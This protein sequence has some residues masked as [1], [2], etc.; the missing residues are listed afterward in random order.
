M[1]R[2]EASISLTRSRVQTRADMNSNDMTDSQIIN[3]NID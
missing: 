1:K 2:Y 3:I